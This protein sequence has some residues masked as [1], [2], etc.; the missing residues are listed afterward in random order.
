LLTLGTAFLYLSTTTPIVRAQGAPAVAPPGTVDEVVVTRQRL[1]SMR[2][3]LE[4]AQEDLYKVFN[5]NT[6]DH[7]LDMAKRE[8]T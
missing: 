1:S 7:E 4:H 2:R 8:V 5:A 3:E 6:S